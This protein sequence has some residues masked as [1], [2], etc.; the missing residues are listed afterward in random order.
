MVTAEE[1]KT[2]TKIEGAGTPSTS[3]GAAVCT[4]YGGGGA[5]ILQVYGSASA[6]ES[7][8]TAF[9]GLYGGKTADLPGVGD[10]A[11]F[12]EGKTGPMSTATLSATKG[13]NAIS[14]QVMGTGSDAAARKQAATDLAKVVLTKL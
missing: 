6:Y 2:A 1:L 8:R 3:G 12:I 10:K 11:F 9:E 14:V 13:S 5:A 4:W 7:S